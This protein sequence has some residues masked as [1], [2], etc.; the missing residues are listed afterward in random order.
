MNVN[1]EENHAAPESTGAVV[2]CRH[3]IWKSWRWTKHFFGFHNKYCRKAGR[4]ELTGHKQI[5]EPFCDVTDR[6]F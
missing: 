5:K 2:R 6:E 4:W 1:N 3:W